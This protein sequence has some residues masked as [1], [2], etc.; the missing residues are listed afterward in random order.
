MNEAHTLENNALIAEFMGYKVLT[1]SFQDKPVYNI[2]IEGSIGYIPE[3]MKYNTSYDWLMPVVEKIENA[4]TR[5]CVNH[6]F[7]H[8]IKCLGGKS[9]NCYIEVGNQKRISITSE[10]R[11]QSIYEAVGT[12]IKWYNENNKK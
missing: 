10:N 6:I 5:S 12:F 9:F 8:I 11:L 3:M 4:Q 1:K 2:P 7:T